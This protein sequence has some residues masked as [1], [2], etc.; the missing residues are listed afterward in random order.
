[1]SDRSGGFFSSVGRFFSGGGSSKRRSSEDSP[2][3]NYEEDESANAAS[4]STAPPAALLRDIIG[5]DRESVNN[6]DEITVDTTE[7]NRVG[8]RLRYLSPSALDKN[9]DSSGGLE[10]EV[11]PE[12]DIFFNTPSI[13]TNRK[14]QLTELDRHALPQS[15]RSETV[16]RSRQLNRSLLEPTLKG[17]LTNER[18]MDMSWC[19]ELTGNHSPASSVTNFSLLSRHSGATTNGSLSSRTQEIFKRLEDANTPAKEVQRMTMLRAGLTRPESWETNPSR[20][21]NQGVTST[22]TP[23]PP[24]RKA[25][26]AIPSRIQLISK[27]VGLSARRTPYWKDLTRNKT[28]LRNGDSESETSSLRMLN[29]TLA[30]AELSSIFSLD[31]PAPKKTASSTSSTSTATMNSINNKKSHVAIVKGPDGKS[32]G[33]NTFKLNDDLDVE[34]NLHTLPPLPASILSDPKP[35]KLNPESAPKRGFLDNLSFSFNAPKDVV[36]AVGTAKPSS[37][38]SSIQSLSES[39]ADD[40]DSCESVVK[41]TSDDSSEESE[42][43]GAEVID[44]VKESRPQT[45][46]D[47][48]SS[49]EGSSNQSSKDSSPKT[50]KDVDLTPTVTVAVSAGN[51]ECQV[52]LC[53]WPISAPKCGACGVPRPDGNAPAAPVATAP[54]RQLVSNVASFAPATASG[55]K[56]GFGASLSAVPAASSSTPGPFGSSKVDSVSTTLTVKGNAP[57]SQAA[58]NVPTSGAST[59]AAP[60]TM[61]LAPVTS[62]ALTMTPSAATTSAAS[63]TSTVTPAAP[64]T[65]AAQVTSTTTP[66][67]PATSAAPVESTAT[68]ERVA[69]S[70]PDCF[71]SNKSTDDKCPCCGHVKYSSAASTSNVFGSRAFKPAAVSSTGSISFGVGGGSAKPT[72]ATQPIFGFGTTNTSQATAPTQSSGFTF[73]ASNSAAPIVASTSSE[74]VKREGSLFG[75]ISKPIASVPTVAVE[76]RTPLFENKTLFGASKPAEEISQSILGKKETSVTSAAAETT[77]SAAPAP[78][79]FGTTTTPFSGPT[80]LFGQSNSVAQIPTASSTLLFGAPANAAT[81]VEAPK[82]NMFGSSLPA[83]PSATN[84]AGPPPPPTAATSLFGPGTGAS[85]SSSNLFSAKP[86]ESFPPSIFNGDKP[87][88]F[89]SEIGTTTTDGGAPAK[90]GMFSSDPPKL[91]FGSDQKV[92]APKFSGFGG[93]AASTS[94]APTSTGT[95]MFGTSSGSLFGGSGTP[96][97]FAASTTNSSIPTFGTTTTTPFAGSTPSSG[98]GNFNSRP[99]QPANSST[100]ALFAPADSSNPFGGSSTSTSGF[101]F[102]GASSSSSSSGQGVFQFGAPAAQATNTAPGGAFQFG[103]NLAAPQP[104]APGNMDNAFSYQAPSNG[105]RKMALARRRNMQR[106]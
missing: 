18:R 73:G 78:P 59:P 22:A 83:A 62:V 99:S 53:S 32:V 16:K 67:A 48:I 66:A 84:V 103:N 85:L 70:C 98:F 54:Q 97:P 27:S 92:E 37:I 15:F 26:D 65:S 61:S 7:N 17:T 60:N 79:I 74:P 8:S 87:I 81:V 91:S 5:M 76:S 2:K 40:S 4:P 42:D 63:V 56:F 43:S 105:A 46:A 93:A 38:T 47:T 6:S 34:D 49:A 9:R 33:R 45:S 106:K 41:Q 104:P 29:G 39:K 80:P 69:W 31:P 21:H 23:P 30:S 13:S 100:T 35:L 64:A 25:G 28:S 1:M 88:R 68:G 95:S 11:N 14:R 55:V 24:L 52:C 102:G 3:S 101:N 19:G 12:Q 57:M 44:E 72:A 51:W 58:G 89:N 90:R 77:T 82:K 94:T 20:D 10:V 36:A 75:N 96:N 71:V 50:A 86:A